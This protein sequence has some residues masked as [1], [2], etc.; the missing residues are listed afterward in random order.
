[1]FY[2]VWCKKA[3][4]YQAAVWTWPACMRCATDA[5]PGRASCVFVCRCLVVEKRARQAARAGA[6]LF[7]PPQIPLP[8][9]QPV[10]P[11]VCRALTARLATKRRAVEQLQRMLSI[12][13]V[14]LERYIL[15]APLP[16]L[17]YQNYS[18]VLCCYRC[19][20]H[21]KPYKLFWSFPTPLL[22]SSH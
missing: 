16:L 20:W 21:R 1:M 11:A 12:A 17:S 3:R 19:F 15:S 18:F 5:G 10:S 8:H 9:V 14:N 2:C 22:G 6:F 4:R 7:C 13:P